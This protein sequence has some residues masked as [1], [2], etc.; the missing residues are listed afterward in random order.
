MLFWCFEQSLLAAFYRVASA[1]VD[2]SGGEFLSRLAAGVAL[3]GVKTTV[4]EWRTSEGTGSCVPLAPPVCLLACKQGQST[5]IRR[6]WQ[7]RRHRFSEWKS[8]PRHR[9]GWLL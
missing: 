2:V 3:A 7:S 5:D 9:H 8:G 6:N 1:K 4:C